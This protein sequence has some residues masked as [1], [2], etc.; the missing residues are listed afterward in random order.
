MRCCLAVKASIAV[1]AAHHGMQCSARCASMP[2]AMGSVPGSCYGLLLEMR[3][4]CPQDTRQCCAKT[5]GSAIICRGGLNFKSHTLHSRNTGA[6]GQST[7]NP[8]G[9]SGV[10]YQRLFV[11]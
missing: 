10:K 1:Q 9:S 8:P 2:P 5:P 11:C 7:V 3:Q 4:C 6:L